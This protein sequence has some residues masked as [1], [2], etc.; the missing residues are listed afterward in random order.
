MAGRGREPDGGERQPPSLGVDCCCGDGAR[1]GLRASLL[2]YIA[3]GPAE[4]VLEGL[5]RDRGPSAVCNTR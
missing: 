2:A 5:A 3:V 4:E 1:V